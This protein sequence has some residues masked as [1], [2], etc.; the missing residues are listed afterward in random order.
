MPENSSGYKV[1][2]VKCG[3]YD[4]AEVE[5]A[6]KKAV[7]LIG[8]IAHFIKPGEKVL[9]KPNLLT[10]VVPEKGIDTHP[11]IVRAVIR[12]VKPITKNIF[13]GDSPNVWSKEKEVDRVYE[14]S[15]IKRIC[16]EEG[17]ELVYFTNPVIKNGYPVVDWAFKCD[18]LINIPKFKSHAFTVLTAGVKNLFGLIIG[19]HKMKVHRENPL[20]ADFSR[21]IVDIYQIRKPDLNILDGIVAMEGQGPGSSG[22]LK[23]MSLVAAADNAVCMDMVLS[24]LMKLGVYDIPTNKE[25]ISRGLGPA[26]LSSIKVCGEKIE[27][28]QPADFKLAKAN[29]LVKLPSWVLDILSIS[30]NSRPYINISKCKVC[31]ACMKSCPVGAIS[32][33]R[34]KFVI[35]KKVCILCLCCQEVCPHAAINVKR[36]LPMCIWSWA[37]TKEPRKA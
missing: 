35:N 14:A 2:L 20:P 10:D 18:K 27:V 1:S 6:V 4:T 23:K 12:L 31:G 11:E 25:A 15:C 16:Q 34:G 36:S 9:L 8:G 7:D 37:F 32:L 5:I 13:C 33:V 29:V 3:S 19:L 21:K 30:L 26:S 24:S 22:T 28:F 17:V